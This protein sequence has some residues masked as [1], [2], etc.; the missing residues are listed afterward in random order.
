MSLYLCFYLILYPIYYSDTQIIFILLFQLDY[1][2]E[3]DATNNLELTGIDSCT[4]ILISV[5]AVSPSGLQGQAANTTTTT[6]EAEPSEPQSF[7][8]GATTATTIELSWFPPAV[9]TII[10]KLIRIS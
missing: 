2:S 1:K 8:A 10:W 3:R 4:E 7:E 6:L 5:Y 9:S